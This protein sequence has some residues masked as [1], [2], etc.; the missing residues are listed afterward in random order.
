MVNYYSILG[1]EKTATQKEIKKAYRRLILKWH[2]DR[3]LDIKETAKKKSQEIN[4]AFRILSDEEMKEFYDKYE[5]HEERNRGQN[6]T[7]CEGCK[8]DVHREGKVPKKCGMILKAVNELEDLKDMEKHIKETIKKAKIFNEQKKNGI[9]SERN[10]WIQEL[11][12]LSDWSLLSETLQNEFIEKTKKCRNAD[13]FH[14]VLDEIGKLREKEGG[15]DNLAELRAQNDIKEA[16]SKEVI[17]DNY[18]NLANILKQIKELR[19]TNAYQ[20][21]E[22]EIKALETRLQELDPSQYQK[23]SQDLLEQQIKSNGLTENNMDEETKK[24]VAEAKQDPTNPVKIAQAEEKIAQNGTDNKLNSLITQSLN[25][26]KK[27]NLTKK[28]KEEIINEFTSFIATDNKYKKMAYQKQKQ[29]VDA[30]LAQLQGE[31]NQ[32]ETPPMA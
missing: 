31:E 16:P 6:K 19:S 26:L 28:E 27:G 20:E 8:R 17:L 18:Q 24:A 32:Q 15:N 9:G 1:V 10:G 7:H 12:N 29:K 13:R 11:K 21:K 5:E 23:T 22:A 2:P 30:L 25:K 14:K 4:E 3:N